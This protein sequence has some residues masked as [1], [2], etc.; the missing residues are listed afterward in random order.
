[1]IK[2]KFKLKSV[3]LGFSLVEL[4]VVLA[5]LGLIFIGV[6]SNIDS[7]RDVNNQKE[8][9]AKVSN[10]KK[11]VLNFSTNFKYL[12][13]PDTDAN[14]D[15][16]EN[17]TLIGGIEVC[18]DVVGTVPYVDLGL[19]AGDV[20]DA[21]DN[22]IRYAVN[23]RSNVQAL[24]CDKRES[25][26]FFC[27]EGQNVFPWFSLL[28][29]PPFVGNPGLGNYT[30]CNESATSGNCTLG[31]A[32][33]LLA[34]NSAVALLV[35]YNQDIEA[36]GVAVN[37]PTAENCD[38]DPLYHQSTRTA[39]QGQFF[40]DVITFISGNEIKNAV[41]GSTLSWTN[42]PSNTPAVPLVPTYEGFDLGDNDYTPSSSNASPDVVVINR[43]L[44]TTSPLDLKNGDDYL[45]IGNNLAEGSGIDAGGGDDTV[46]IVNGAFADVELGSGDDIFVL[47]TNLTNSLDA[48]TGND[49]V[50]IQGNI[51]SSAVLDLGD[52]D[53]TLWLGKNP[54]DESLGT[55]DSNYLTS[56]Q[57]L[58][59][60]DGG[61]GDYDILVLENMTEAEFIANTEFQ[62]HVKNFELVIFK[63]IDGV[64]NHLV[65]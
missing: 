12:P 16:Y 61:S 19:S 11:Q 36:C 35:A 65:L 39:Q 58:A 26:S 44:N 49:S 6:F 57:L 62:S 37:T 32:V 20:L 29:T 4:A 28:D 22:P 54:Y 8:A 1:M 56:G 59:D 50:W 60:I 64:R 7:F 14:P 63:I 41:L 33:N 38:L 48:E 47:E 18:A 45:A 43:D 9:Q 31:A 2:S 24:I 17:R 23:T 53:D 5:V 40:D 21:W 52:G 27:N 46:Y 55:Y 3:E 13:C 30:I 34:S 10:I 51:E 42:Y 15:G 25:A